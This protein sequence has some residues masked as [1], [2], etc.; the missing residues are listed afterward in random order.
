MIF[1]VIFPRAFK[2]SKGVQVQNLH[3]RKDEL[4]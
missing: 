2:A 3:V 4:F 1:L